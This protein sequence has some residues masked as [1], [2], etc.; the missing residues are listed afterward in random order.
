MNNPENA[1]K[2]LT[3]SE[4]AKLIP[5]TNGKCVSTQTLYRWATKGCRGIVLP[6]LRFGRR[7]AIERDSLETF[8]GQLAQAWMLPSTAPKDI[9]KHKTGH[10]S[11]VQR[12]KDIAEA[13]ENLRKSGIIMN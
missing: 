8:A 4:A 7:V 12:E 5:T 13:E 10:R 2:W 1:S 3:L 11:N 6:H 9:K